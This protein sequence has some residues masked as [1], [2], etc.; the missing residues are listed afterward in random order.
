MPLKHLG[1]SIGFSLISG[2]ICYRQWLLDAPRMP[3]FT[4]QILLQQTLYRELTMH[5][6]LRRCVWCSWSYKQEE[7]QLPSKLACSVEGIGNNSWALCVA[8]L[9]K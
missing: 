3:I 8:F 6:A 2:S 5:Q 9:K 1:L 4:T 7:H